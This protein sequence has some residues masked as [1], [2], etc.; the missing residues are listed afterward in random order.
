[1]YYVQDA[2]SFWDF[3]YFIVLIVVGSFF[4]INLCLVVIA[5]QFSETKKREMERMRAERAH[6]QSS[7]TLTS[8]SQPSGCY[9][10]LFRYAGHLLRRASRRLL[11]ACCLLRRRR[12][13]LPLA[14]RPPRPAQP[15]PTTPRCRPKRPTPARDLGRR[16]GGLA[17]GHRRPQ[18]NR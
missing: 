8:R 15:P 3:I 4:M 12:E 16:P 7:S 13:Q 17:Q 14:L 10:Q 18:G 5:T 6:F 1:M 11:P 2:H 9:A